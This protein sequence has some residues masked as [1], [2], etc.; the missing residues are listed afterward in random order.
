MAAAGVTMVASHS[1]GLTVKSASTTKTDSAMACPLVL[2][3]SMAAVATAAICRLINSLSA[4]PF[5][6]ISSPNWAVV[7]GRMVS[8]ILETK[9]SCSGP[10][11]S[12]INETV[13]GAA[14]ERKYSL[15]HEKLELTKASAGPSYKAVIHV[16]HLRAGEG[17]RLEARPPPI[18]RWEHC[19]AEGAI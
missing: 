15:A 1:S 6:L 14:C 19:Q 13:K 17:N 10:M 12:A 18:M 9:K 7:S 8:I 2:T 4:K 5:A 3:G 11:P 16:P